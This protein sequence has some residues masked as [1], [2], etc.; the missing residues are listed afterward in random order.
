MTAS[1]RREKGELRKAQAKQQESEDEKKS[2]QERNCLSQA[3]CRSHETQDQR[4]IRQVGVTFT[5]VSSLAILFHLL[6]ATDRVLEA[7][8]MANETPQEIMNDPPE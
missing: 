8:R 6:Q 5:I 7:S 1:Q 4:E 2:C 3:A